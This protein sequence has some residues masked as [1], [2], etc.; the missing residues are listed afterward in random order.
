MDDHLYAVIMAGGIGSRLWPRSRNHIPKQFLDLLGP[1]TML[2]ETVQRIEPLVPL[3]RLFVVVGPGS[4]PVGIRAGAGAAGRE[5]VGGAVPAQ[6]GAVHR[7]GGDGPAP[8]R[9]GGGDG[10]PCRPTTISP[11]GPV[12]AGP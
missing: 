1:R 12:F 9:P 11:M 6:H 3:S 5:P 10:G 8:A 2:Q 7:A 4:C